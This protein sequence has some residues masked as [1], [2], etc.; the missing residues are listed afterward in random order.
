MLLVVAIARTAG[1]EDN[2]VGQQSIVILRECAGIDI[3]ATL[4][5]GA[6]VHGDTRPCASK[7][8]PRDRCL[9][10]VV[11]NVFM[12]V[13][14]IGVHIIYI[15]A[16]EEVHRE[17]LLRRLCPF[18]SP[19]DGPCLCRGSERLCRYGVVGCPSPFIGRG[20]ALQVILP[21]RILARNR[22]FVDAVVLKGDANA[23][24]CRRSTAE[25]DGCGLGRLITGV[26]PHIVWFIAHNDSGQ[27]LAVV[28]AS[29]CEICL[30]A[31]VTPIPHCDFRIVPS[32]GVFEIYGMC[33][34]IISRIDRVVLHIARNLLGDVRIR[35]NLSVADALI[36]RGEGQVDVIVSKSGNI[37]SLVDALS[38]CVQVAGGE[39]DVQIVGRI[40][41][42]DMILP[43][44]AVLASY[45]LGR[46]MV[47]VGV[48]HHVHTGE[49]TSELRPAVALT[50]VGIQLRTGSIDAHSPSVELDGRCSAVGIIVSIGNR[51]VMTTVGP[52]CRSLCAIHIFIICVGSI[53]TDIEIEVITTG[54][55]LPFGCVGKRIVDS[56]VVNRSEG[57]E[58]LAAAVASNLGEIAVAIIRVVAVLR[59]AAHV[60]DAC[61]LA[62]HNEFLQRRAHGWVEPVL[63]VYAW[64]SGHAKDVG[65]GGKD[66][67]SNHIVGIFHRQVITR[68]I[69]IVVVD[70]GDEIP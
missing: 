43:R 36:A 22:Q 68:I 8:R 33:T 14:C 52:A 24:W 4:L 18:S 20:G 47:L 15:D 31:I 57:H 63:E 5:L 58:H 13:P 65:V 37:I 26:V 46:Y 28:C 40:N 50:D 12:V 27:S 48:L 45:C 29:G 11:V 39:H 51:L 17:R 61:C 60:V 10:F 21:G 9:R 25:H 41:F 1:I 53:G 59:D 42:N 66:V 67:G 32:D 55:L 44:L 34:D 3:I 35:C 62:G 16:V 7:V 49:G 64:C 2:L 54:D 19:H 38:L 23:L 56:L 30:C 70:E 6:K 69:S